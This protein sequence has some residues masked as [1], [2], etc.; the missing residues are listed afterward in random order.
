VGSACH[1]AWLGSEGERSVISS[2]V[3]A[4]CLRAAVVEAEPAVVQLLLAGA[5]GVGELLGQMSALARASLLVEAVTK[6][7]GPTPLRHYD[8][9][10]LL[11]A[12]DEGDRARARGRHHRRSRRAARSPW[13]VVSQVMSNQALN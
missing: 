2:S 9:R 4:A 10:G 5:G 11:A 13:A 6:L 3:G 8:Q 7:S 12:C 1:R